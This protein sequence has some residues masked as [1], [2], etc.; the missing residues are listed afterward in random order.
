MCFIFSCLNVASLGRSRHAERDR[1]Y[2]LLGN[3]L[4]MNVLTTC[5]SG[6]LAVLSQSFLCMTFNADSFI[7]QKIQDFDSIFFGILVERRYVAAVEC[8]YRCFL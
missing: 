1:S 5:L 6:R 7:N 3:V 4:I 2:M 8:L